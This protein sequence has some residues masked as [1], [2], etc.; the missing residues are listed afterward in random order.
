MTRIFNDPSKAIRVEGILELPERIAS[1]VCAGEE[2]A[3]PWEAQS[4]PSKP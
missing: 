3:S 2:L 1:Q 4:L